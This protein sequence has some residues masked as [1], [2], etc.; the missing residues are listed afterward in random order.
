MATYTIGTSGGGYYNSR[1][2]N[3]SPYNYGTAI[4]VTNGQCWLVTD[5]SIQMA[6]NGSTQTV[7]GHIWN[8]AGTD[9]WQGSGVA[10]ASDTVAPFTAKNLGD[11]GASY[12]LNNISGANDT[13]Y[14]GFSKNAADSINWDAENATTG[15]ATGNTA[16]GNLTDFS[17]TA[18]LARKLCGTFTYTSVTAP[19]TPTLTATPGNAQVALSWTAPA[20]GGVA[21]SGY[22][23][24]RGTT[25]I[26]TGT[27]TSFTDTSLTNGTAYSYTVFAT[28]GVGNSSTGSASAT[29]RTIPT[30]PTSFAA[31]TATFGQITLSWAL[32]SS[33]GG[34]AIIGYRLRS[35]TTL[36]S[37]TLLYEGTGTSYAHT[38]LSPY[39][40]YSY[41]IVAYNVAG[42]ST[43]TTNATLTAKTMGGIAR[44]WNGSSYVI[45]LPK[46][47]NGTAWVDAQARI[48]DGTEWK[49]GI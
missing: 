21:I 11:P 27:N 10:I 43:D 19:G 25:T 39:T 17:P 49:Y 14:V 15:T 1:G 20:N 35:G 24:K 4:T 2:A 32:P 22:T 40:D 44:I 34:S 9:Y 23:L 47:W 33:N 12:L 41:N 28:N 29:P 36:G 16:H 30:A 45:T 13:W 26:Y 8:S 37:G 48:W 42:E 7:Y 18:S 38:G 6:G 5:V 31:D 3:L 46:V